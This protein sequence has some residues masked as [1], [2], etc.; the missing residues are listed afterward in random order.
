MSKFY[1]D[2]DSD[3]SQNSKPE[4]SNHNHKQPA[5]QHYQNY[6][7]KP[8]PPKE[9]SKLL[10]IQRGGH[11]TKK[12]KELFEKYVADLRRVNVASLGDGYRVCDIDP[13]IIFVRLEKEVR[14]RLF[15]GE[16]GVTVRIFEGGG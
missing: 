10:F 11:Q 3:Y 13:V 4:S 16:D 15:K 9:I 6:R 1:G 5:P 12:I 2:C 14:G 7:S 8:T